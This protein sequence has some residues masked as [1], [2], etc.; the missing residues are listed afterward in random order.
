MV[1]TMR[2][3]SKRINEDQ[4]P[5][6]SS[7]QRSA[8]HMPAPLVRQ[9]SKQLSYVDEVR[10]AS[11][12]ERRWFAVHACSFVVVF[13]V[14]G[15]FVYHGFG[16]LSWLDA[17][18][19]CTVTLTTVGY[20]DLDSNHNQGLKIF[21]CVFIICGVGIIASFLAF[22]VDMLL[23]KEE[24]LIIGAI[25]SGTT[26]EDER[27]EGTRS[28]ETVR[29]LSSLAVFLGL[30]I[31]AILVF[32]FEGNMT[33]VE[34]VYLVIVSAST[35]GYGDLAPNTDFAKAFATFFLPVLTLSLAKTLGDYAEYVL[36]KRIASVQTR[37]LDKKIDRAKFMAMDENGDGQIDR[38]E[39]VTGRLIAQEKIKEKDVKEALA[40][41][42]EMDTSNKG[43]DSVVFNL[44]YWTPAHVYS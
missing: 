42:R 10:E 44:G 5:L 9:L 1:E 17:A 41:F 35:V 26:V 25:Q 28:P 34:S 33:V 13:Y 20:G 19:F 23:T 2:R 4:A 21:A 36:D 37:V 3:P 27:S 12:A 43:E 30:C 18:Y 29:L 7:Q 16:G 24:G 40:K 11:K 22:L 38:L 15:T 32:C 8:A 31:V 6:L 14:M 39:F